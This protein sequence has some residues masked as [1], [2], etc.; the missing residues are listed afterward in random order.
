MNH[1]TESEI[2]FWYNMLYFI[3][4]H[5]INVSKPLNIGPIEE[6]KTTK[7]AVELEESDTLSKIF[8]GYWV[9]NALSMIADRQS[10]MDQMKNVSKR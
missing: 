1:G 8:C 5:V 4:S 9:L 7:T 10:Q 2:A 3:G 6:A